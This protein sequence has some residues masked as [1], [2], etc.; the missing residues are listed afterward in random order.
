MELIQYPQEKCGAGIA[1]AIL[2]LEDTAWPQ[3]P[4]EQSFPSAPNTYVTSF[5][6]MEKG[7]AGERQG[8]L[9]CRHKKKRAASQGRSISG[10]WAERSGNTSR[11]PGKRACDADHPK[12][13]GVSC[14]AR[15]GSQHFYLREG[16]CWPVCKV[17]MGANARRLPGGRDQKQTVS[18]RQPN[19][20]DHD[21]AAFPKSQAA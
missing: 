9:P 19:P 3:G 1:K 20:G 12:G 6:L 7:R 13:G 15:S 4:E 16:E 17:R 21:A 18:Q 10:V 2:A 14:R 5:I 8:D 11:I